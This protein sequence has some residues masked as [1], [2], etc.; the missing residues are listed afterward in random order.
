[1]SYGGVPADDLRC[2]TCGASY[3]NFD[4]HSDPEEFEILMS[5]EITAYPRSEWYI[6]CP[7]GHKWTIKTVWRTLEQPDEVLLGRYLGEA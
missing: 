4:L 1:M 2:P 3:L 6:L 7:N 5:T